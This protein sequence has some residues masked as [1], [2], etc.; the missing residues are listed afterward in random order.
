MT[1]EREAATDI[2]HHLQIFK[3][4]EEQTHPASLF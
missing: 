1:T 2:G 4:V 3:S